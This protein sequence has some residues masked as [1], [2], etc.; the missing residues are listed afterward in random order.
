MESHRSTLNRYESKDRR[1]CNADSSKRDRPFQ[2]LRRWFACLRC[3]LWISTGES[4]SRRISRRERIVWPKCR[5]GPVLI[6]WED[7]ETWRADHSLGPLLSVVWPSSQITLVSSS[8]TK[9][10]ALV[11][12]VCT[13][14]HSIWGEEEGDC[15][16]L[17]IVICWS[18]A[19]RKNSLRML[20]ALIW[21]SI[22][23]VA[24]NVSMIPSIKLISSYHWMASV[25]WSA[26]SAIKR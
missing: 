15:W 17:S 18:K 22:E 21:T 12:M 24:R 20:T 4:S 26:Q 8:W 6:E 14:F 11:S 16:L 13:V 19:K 25:R 23:S 7:R 10:V 9:Y 1:N 3:L 2:S 5:R